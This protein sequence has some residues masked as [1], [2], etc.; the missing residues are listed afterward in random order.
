MRK[1]MYQLLTGE[2]SLTT[3]VPAPGWYEQGA[4]VDTPAERPF[5]IMKFS[6]TP[7]AAGKFSV[8][9]LWCYDDRG[10]YTRIDDFL[11]AARAFFET[12]PVASRIRDDDSL[13]RLVF[14]DWQ[15]DSADLYDDVF[16][17]NTRYSSWRLVGSGQ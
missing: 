4:V 16:R 12:E 13:V 9:E 10:D 15:G 8:M 7:R 14:A 1:L 11:R 5:V 6:G 2:P 17:C 3:L